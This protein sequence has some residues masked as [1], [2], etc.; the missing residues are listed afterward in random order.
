MISEYLNVDLISAL[1]L[2]KMSEEKRNVLV[3]EMEQVLLSRVNNAL[4]AQ[5]SD[6]EI[7]QLN[8]VVDAEGDVMKFYTTRVPN[9]EILISEIVADF[10]KEMIGLSE[11]VNEA[12]SKEA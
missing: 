7:E 3:H 12:A 8:A 11:M 6:E 2:D 9:A 4:A 1:G 5:L 10:K